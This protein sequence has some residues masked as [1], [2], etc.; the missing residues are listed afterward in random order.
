MIWHLQIN[1][2]STLFP[3]GDILLVP[4]GAK[5]CFPQ[6]HASNCNCQYWLKRSLFYAL[7]SNIVRSLHANFAFVF[8]IDCGR[9]T[10]R[11]VPLCRVCKKCLECPLRFSNGSSNQCLWTS[12][13]AGV[14]RNKTLS[15]LLF[16]TFHSFAPIAQKQ[17]GISSHSLTNQPLVSRPITIASTSR[18]INSTYHAQGGTPFNVGLFII[19]LSMKFCSFLLNNTTIDLSQSKVP[20]PGKNGTRLCD[21]SKSGFCSKLHYSI[22]WG[23]ASVVRHEVPA[24]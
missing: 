8:D 1:K 22:H 20:S 18:T 9:H 23:M 21:F 7:L 15:E 24:A 19:T 14:L 16:S 5:R 13:E 11:L 12:F 4:T 2:R 6:T 10:E 3:Y 17:Y